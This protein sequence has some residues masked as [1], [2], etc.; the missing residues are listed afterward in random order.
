MLQIKLKLN[1]NNQKA[2]NKTTFPSSPAGTITRATAA[3]AAVVDSQLHFYRQ[4]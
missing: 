4:D 3:A 2:T 1:C